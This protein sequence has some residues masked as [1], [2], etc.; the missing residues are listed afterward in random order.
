M[1]FDPATYV[2]GENHEAFDENGPIA[3]IESD[4][5]APAPAPA[6]SGEPAAPAGATKAD[7]DRYAWMRAQ[8]AK[9]AAAPAAP[10]PTGDQP[11]GEEQPEAETQLEAEQQEQTEQQQTVE[12]YALKVPDFVDHRAVTEERQQYFDDFQ[13][14][15]PQVGIAAPEAQALVDVAVDAATALHY[16]H[17]PE[18]TAEDARATMLQLFGEKQGTTLIKEAQ[19][20]AHSRGE[21]FLNYLD[22]TG[23]GSDPSVLVALACAK[24]GWFGPKATPA[25]AQDQITKVMK[26]STYTSGDK[27]THIKL[28][29]LA[30]IAHRDAGSQNDQLRA[31]ATTAAQAQLT[32]KPAAGTT[33]SAGDARAE[34]TKLLD[35]KGPLLRGG[36]GQAEAKA[37]YFELLKKI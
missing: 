29:T 33:P 18:A 37:R 17:N 13:Q 4:A 14:V 21:K 2:P 15:A 3:A 20:Y 22:E 11:G 28:Q 32:A 12:P 1:V 35:P 24:W 9:R 30:R 8:A 34:I 7:S 19:A 23:L 25:W 26:H 31:A 6:P 5:A 10:A 36:P 27:L 16:Q